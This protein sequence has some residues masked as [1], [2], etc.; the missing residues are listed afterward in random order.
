M[1]DD[2]FFRL[3]SLTSDSLVV[4]CASRMHSTSFDRSIFF[5]KLK[6]PLFCYIKWLFSSIGCLSI[7]KS[8]IMFI[9]N[10]MLIKHSKWKRMRECSFEMDLREVTGWSLPNRILSITFVTLWFHLMVPFFA[11][12]HQI[13]YGVDRLHHVLSTL[14]SLWY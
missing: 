6:V 13:K 10:V 12:P 14:E 11:P 9:Q 7:W 2:N 4:P 5:L 1:R 8:W 3:Q